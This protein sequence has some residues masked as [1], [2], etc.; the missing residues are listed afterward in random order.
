[1]A[2]NQKPTDTKEKS[3]D[4]EKLKSELKEE[5]KAEVRTE[6]LQDI[7]ADK[8]AIAKKNEE[9][10]TK[11]E[12]MLAKQE[13]G[14][15]EKLKSEN[16]VDIFIPESEIGDNTPVP[17]GINGVVYTIPRGKNF[18]V[19]ESIYKLWYESYTRTAAANRRI[20]VT[21]LENAEITITG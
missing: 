2:N 14:T 16:Q 17:V 9:M 6:V 13:K 12:A 4:I 11:S 21:K 5:L 10:E 19:P 20:K 8:A 3:I 7:E 15:L 18:K 1:M